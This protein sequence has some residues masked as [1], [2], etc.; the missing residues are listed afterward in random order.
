MTQHVRVAVV[1]AGFGGLGTGIRLKQEGIDDFVVLERAPEV[2]GTWQINSYP[3]A[4]CDVPSLIYS[5]S[6]AP[7]PNWSRLYPLQGELK[8]YMHRCAVDFGVLPH[9]RFSTEVTDASW[10]DDACVWRISTSTGDLTAQVLVGAI[11]PFSAPSIPDLPGLER[12]RGKVFHSQA[13]DHDHD[14]S[15]ERV[16]VIGTGASAVQFIPRVQP[17]AGH[18]SVFQRTPI[19]VL[20]HPDRPVGALT[21]RLYKRVPCAQAA[22]RKAW[23]LTFEALVPG[24][25][26]EPRLQKP[27]EWL[28]RALLNRQVKDPD[29]R[30]R[31][32]PSYAVGCKRPTF[33]NA[34]YPALTAANT[35]VVTDGIVEVTERGIVTADGAEH[36]LDTIIFGTGF[37]MTDHPG[38]E[39]IH[40]RDGTSLAGQW[41]SGEMTAYLG[42][43]IHNFPNLFLILGPNS[44]VYTSAVITIEDQVHYILDALRAMERRDLS[45]IEVT[46]E[47][48]RSF[49]EW[50][51]RGLSRSVFLTGGCH[52]YYLSRSGRNFTHY[53]GFSAGF[54]ART[55]EIDLDHYAAR[56]AEPSIVEVRA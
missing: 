41:R 44:G 26:H 50:I 47:A 25:I 33:S 19:W 49:V 6:F 45:W 38:F 39:L 8:E 32:T 27:L 10:D 4:Q 46:A 35:T 43:A 15:G 9:V 37:R 20:P 42:T 29:L 17:R 5:Y 24:F 48:E 36:Q 12:F 14:L 40:G 56:R 23:A 28:A 51:D 7:N 16:G 55:R 2:G 52:S 11:G 1:G 22:A 34:Y 54:R 18:L 21:R 13:W 3:G 53:P 31:L 30:A